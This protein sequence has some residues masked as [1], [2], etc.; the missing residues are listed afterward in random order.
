VSPVT[1][2]Y[3]PQIQQEPGSFG[4]WMIH[5]LAEEYFPTTSADWPTSNAPTESYAVPGPVRQ[6]VSTLTETIGVELVGVLRA[7]STGWWVAW[8]ASVATEGSFWNWIVA[9]K[10]VIVAA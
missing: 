7:E 8:D 5:Q 4:F 2:A 1:L 6:L 3:W 9:A 10:A